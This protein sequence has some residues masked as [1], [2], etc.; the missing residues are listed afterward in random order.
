MILKSPKTRLG[1]TNLLSDFILNKIP[2]DELSVIQVVDCKNLIIIKGQTT[3]SEILEISKIIDEFKEKYSELLSDIKLTNFIDIIEYD[4]KLSKTEKIIQSYY[5]T[6]SCSY[7]FSQIENYE[8]DDSINYSDD[9][10]SSEVEESLVVCSSFP[11]GYSLKMGRSLYYLGKHIVYNIP[12]TSPFTKVT[13][14]IH[15]NSEFLK[16]FDNF[17]NSYD[18]TLTSA[19]LDCLNYDTTWIETEIKK[20]DFC[21]ETTNPLSEYDFIKKIY[22]DL[23]II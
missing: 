5:N 21:L 18:E 14:T 8:K 3:S 11:H 6:E 22:K 2:S 17:Y 15:E 1:I 9:Y 20:V 13:L 19:I 7:N 16:I 23:I 12:P 4:S 10:S